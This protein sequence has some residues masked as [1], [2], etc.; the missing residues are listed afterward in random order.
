M[1]GGAGPGG[2]KERPHTKVNPHGPL[3]CPSVS[4]S[5]QSCRDDAALQGEADVAG[6]EVPHR[7][8]A[9]PDALHATGAGERMLLPPAATLR[10]N[11]DNDLHSLASV[12]RA[13]KPASVRDSAR[14]ITRRSEIDCACVLDLSR[15]R[16]SAAQSGGRCLGVAC[17]QGLQTHG[18][19]R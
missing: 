3:A 4:P 11:G 9:C 13:A 5:P 16:I 18:A 15:R 6:E 10:R 8:H 17:G 19:R 1:L 7:F 12:E 14:D 2:R